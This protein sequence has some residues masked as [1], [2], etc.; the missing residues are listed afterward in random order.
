MATDT[1]NITLGDVHQ[2]ILSL[3]EA[4]EQAP[5]KK[6]PL[7]K[8]TYVQV[9]LALFAASFGCWLMCLTSWLTALALTQ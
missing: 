3:E 5:P 1:K 8:K 7:G 9:G 2:Y 6:V 4:E